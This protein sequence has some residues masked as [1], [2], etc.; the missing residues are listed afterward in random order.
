[1]QAIVFA[2]DLLIV[3]GGPFK[4]AEEAPP[5]NGGGKKARAD[6]LNEIIKAS[7]EC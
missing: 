4:D 5:A 7:E 6:F 1:M 2:R 3:H